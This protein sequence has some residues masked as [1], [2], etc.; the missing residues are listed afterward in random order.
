MNRKDANHIAAALAASFDRSFH[1]Q[2]AATAYFYAIEAVASAIEPL[3]PDFNRAAFLEACRAR[4]EP[5]E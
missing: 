4:P 3:A 5:A 1:A 2:T